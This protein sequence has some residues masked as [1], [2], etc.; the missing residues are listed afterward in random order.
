M[1]IVKVS[2]YTERFF[3]RITLYLLN[4]SEYISY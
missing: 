2:K 3:E 1:Y 4:S